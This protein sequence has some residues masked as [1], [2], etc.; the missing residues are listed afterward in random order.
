MLSESTLADCEKA[1]N[2]VLVE[3]LCGEQPVRRLVENNNSADSL[4]RPEI[5]KIVRRVLKNDLEDKVLSIIKRELKA[6]TFE[7]AVT[8]VVVKALA[9]YHEIMFTRKSTW[10]NQLRSK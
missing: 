7:N 3:T 8:D 10:T 2:Q 1:V 9:R 4:T 5:E 6:T